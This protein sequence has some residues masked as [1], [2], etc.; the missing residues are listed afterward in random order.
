MRDPL[1]ELNRVSFAYREGEP[2][3]QQINLIIPE[4]QWV[5][6]AGAN[7]SG[8]S[9]LVKL[10]NGLLAPSEG[11]VYIGAMEVMPDTLVEIR[12][13]VGM[14]FQNPDNQFVGTT[15]EEDIV[16]G[17]ENRCLDIEEM[18]QR[19]HQY[20]YKLQIADL[21]DKHPSQLSGGQKQ[22]VAIAGV[23]AVE[24]DIVVFDE[25]TSMLDERA[26][27]NIISLM[28]QMRAERRY[29]MITITHDTDEIAASDRVVVLNGGNVAADRTPEELFQDEKLLA[30]CR[31]K[32]PFHMQ[33]CRRLRERGIQVGLHLGE[34]ELLE[35]L[36][37][38]NSKK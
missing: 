22:R 15:V 32:E 35:E 20:A 18:K 25:S 7:G 6:I 14:I 19:L 31:L 9:T 29:T 34:K 24:P 16:F 4:G 27:R 38:F 28:K 23:L 10:L 33:V 3:L 26:K 17:L 36:C 30:L 12:Q 2:L 13:K 21:L 5:S 37:R 8:K 11:R 1:I